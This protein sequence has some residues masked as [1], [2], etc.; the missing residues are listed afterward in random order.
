MTTHFC[1]VEQ[2]VPKGGPAFPTQNDSRYFHGMTVRD[3]F[4]A[5]AIPSAILDRP[6]SLWQ[7]IRRLLGLTYVG[8]TVDPVHAAARAY[9]MADAMLAERGRA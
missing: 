3:Y 9:A 8:S 6:R 1:N 5:Q 7:A 4:A 2:S